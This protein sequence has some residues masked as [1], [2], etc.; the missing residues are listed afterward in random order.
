MIHVSF[1]SNGTLRNT[2]FVTVKEAQ[3]LTGRSRQTLWRDTKSGKISSRKRQE[4]TVYD[5]SELER[6]YGPL[7]PRNNSYGIK[8]RNKLPH[9]TENKQT[10]LQQENQFLVEKNTDLINQ[11]KKAEEREEKLQDT[12]NKLT[13]TTARQ[14]LILENK[15]ERKGII[16]R[17]LGV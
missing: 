4:R 17:I 2:A 8:E 6:Y 3:K 14:T 11:L 13:E 5:I 10:L 7:S 15:S 9:E 12:I 16:A 1:M